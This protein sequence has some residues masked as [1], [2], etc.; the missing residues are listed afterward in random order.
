MENASKALIIAGAILISI[1]LIGVGVLIVG[2][3]Q[4]IFGGAG[5]KIS[6][7]EIEQFN[8]SFTPYEGKQAGSNIRSLLQT[9]ATHNQTYTG[10]TSKQIKLNNSDFVMSQ[11]S[12]TKA[13]VNVGTTYTVEFGYDGGSGMINNIIITS[14]TGTVISPV[15]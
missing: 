13:S 7:M 4:G 5:N 9:M 2:N 11:L 10:D 8:S 1:V 3:A 6:Q 15:N 12:K 14:S